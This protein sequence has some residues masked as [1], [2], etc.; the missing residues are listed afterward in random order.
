M[1]MR[2]NASSYNIIVIADDFRR[3]P[4]A[5][6]IHNMCIC[7]CMCR[8]HWGKEMHSEAV[9]FVTRRKPFTLKKIALCSRFLP[10]MDR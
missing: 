9:L 6:M 5:A 2:F 10:L 7:M 4:K 8:F 1:K 3:Y